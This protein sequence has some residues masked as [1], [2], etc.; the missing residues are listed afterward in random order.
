ML[1]SDSLLEVL[2]NLCRNVPT[3]LEETSG[4]LSTLTLLGGEDGCDFGRS[5][6]EGTVKYLL[7]FISIT[8]FDFRSLTEFSA[9]L[10]VVVVSEFDA[11][12]ISP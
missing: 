10:G 12:D 9:F 1:L 11:L 7:V 6:D 5:S 2:S 4:V 3:F 8:L